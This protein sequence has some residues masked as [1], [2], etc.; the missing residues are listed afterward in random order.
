MAEDLRMSKADE[1]YRTT[2]QAFEPSI[3]CLRKVNIYLAHPG[4]MKLEARSRYDGRYHEGMTIKAPYNVS[5]INDHS[6]CFHLQRTAHRL[7]VSCQAHS[8]HCMSQDWRSGM[9]GG[10]HEAL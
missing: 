6:P 4:C 5:D 7:I 8:R 1:A 3:R 10:I 2:L 9:V